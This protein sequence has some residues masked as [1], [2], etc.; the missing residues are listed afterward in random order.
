MKPGLGSYEF[1]KVE[2]VQLMIDLRETEETYS[3]RPTRERARMIAAKMLPRLIDA[4]NANR[5][6]QDWEKRNAAK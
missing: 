2:E 1:L 6:H 3:R 5:A 4:L